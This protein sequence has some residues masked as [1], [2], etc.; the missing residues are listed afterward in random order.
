MRIFLDN[1][2][3]EYE[4]VGTGIPVLFIHGFPLS[5]KMWSPQLKGL[6]DFGLLVSLDLRGHGDS[7]PFD[8]PYSME[9]LA[10]DCVKLMEFLNVR[11]PFVVCGLSMGGY[12]I[13]AMYRKYPE[14]FRGMILSST[15]PEPDSPDAKKVRDELIRNTKVNGTRIIAD[16]MLPNLFSSVTLTKNPRL[17]EQIQIMMTKTSVQG[18]IGALQ[19]IR[20]RPDSGSLLS[21]I[22]CPVLIVHGTDDRIVP[23]NEAGLMEH[24]ISNSHLVKIKDAGHL[25]N[26]EQPVK[27][28]Q[29]LR[30]FLR[31]LS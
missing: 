23:M 16:T 14:L 25:P 24:K 15:R 10:D 1:G 21:Q 20:D 29:T 9:L 31:S 17:S 22:T 13:M 8:G 5:R 11:P 26:L 12:V 2:F 6:S 4:T 27:Y 3:L 18:I 28:N 7:Y 19:G 30:D